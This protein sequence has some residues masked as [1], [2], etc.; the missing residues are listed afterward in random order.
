MQDDLIR[1]APA[2]LSLGPAEQAPADPAPAHPRV[3]D[4][5]LELPLALADLPQA[6][7]RDH[8]LLVDADDLK[9]G[10]VE[11]VELLVG[12]HALLADEHPDAKLHRSLELGGITGRTHRDGEAAVGAQLS[13]FLVSC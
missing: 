4:H 3:D 2:G 9:R 8:A 13:V 1:P 10:L 5:P 6:A 11:V 12:V 7:G